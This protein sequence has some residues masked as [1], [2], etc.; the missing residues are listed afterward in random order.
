V[1]QAA[2]R[3]LPATGYRLPAHFCPQQ[4]PGQQFAPLVQQLA[5]QQLPGQHF[6]DFVQHAALVAA[7][8]ESENSDAASKAKSFVFMIGFLSM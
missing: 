8:A 5:P 1:Q 4:S 2:S 3:R 7:R 6:A